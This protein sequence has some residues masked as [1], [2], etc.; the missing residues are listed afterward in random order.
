MLEKKNKL[1]RLRHWKPLRRGETRKNKD[2]SVL[3]GNTDTQI[4]KGT[5]FSGWIY[6]FKYVIQCSVKKK[7]DNK[8]FL[9]NLFCAI[10]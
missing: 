7:S 1:D 4:E 6:T 3:E 2:Y 10:L 8:C 5:L 9:I